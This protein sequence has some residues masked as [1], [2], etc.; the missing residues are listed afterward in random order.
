MT[1]TAAWIIFIVLILISAV[2]N[3]FGFYQEELRIKKEKEQQAKV[4]KKIK[5]LNLKFNETRKN[6]IENICAHS[7]SICKLKEEIA[8]KQEQ[9][10]QANKK[11][12]KIQL[13][14]QEIEKLPTKRSK[15][16]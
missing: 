1:Q 4:E 16:K 8:L 9:I 3:G 15:R 14:I 2:F 12:K 10:N 6:L 5:T 13:Q 11:I 7:Q